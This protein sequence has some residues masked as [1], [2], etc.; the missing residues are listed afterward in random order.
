[1]SV[2]R[3]VKN[4]YDHQTGKQPYFKELTEQT[5]EESLTIPKVNPKKDFRAYVKKL[6]DCSISAYFENHPKP[7]LEQPFKQSQEATDNSF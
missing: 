5:V 2:F 3:Q 6:E 4:M 1:M 7:V